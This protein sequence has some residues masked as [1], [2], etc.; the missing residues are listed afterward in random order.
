MIRQLIAMLHEALVEQ[1]TFI[2]A[3]QPDWSGLPREI[4]LDSTETSTA[5]RVMHERG[6]HL[7]TA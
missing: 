4:K 1:T 6:R 3:A 2:G 5:G 7:R